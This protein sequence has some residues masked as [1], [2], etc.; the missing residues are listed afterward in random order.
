MNFFGLAVSD[1]ATAL[2]Y[3]DFL[4]WCLNPSSCMEYGR[5]FVVFIFLQREQVK[6][7][8]NISSNRYTTMIIYRV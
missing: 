2:A 4:L 5:L 1:D 7:P 6:M 8:I 3:T